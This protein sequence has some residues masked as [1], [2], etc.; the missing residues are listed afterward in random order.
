[1]FT[2]RS[3]DS[4]DFK[5]VCDF[6][7]FS[8]SSRD[9]VLS[10]VEEDGPEC[11]LDGLFKIAVAKNDERTLSAQLEADLLQV[12]LGARLHDGVPD[13]GA[14]SEAQFAHFWVVGDGLAGH[15]AASRKHVD[16]AGRDAGLGCELSKLERSQRADL[17]G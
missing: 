15:A 13:P 2:F 8:P 3:H 9:T 6:K 16:D 17:R 7:I 14:A 11:G 5:C 12:G 1:L 4:T 10:L